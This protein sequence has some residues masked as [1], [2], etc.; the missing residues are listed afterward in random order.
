M[1]RIAAGVV[2]GWVAVAAVALLAGG[3]LDDVRVTSGTSMLA[4]GA[5]SA[6]VLD[7]LA[8]QDGR[9]VPALV[10]YERDGPLQAGDLKAARRD[11]RRFTAV[12][13]VLGTASDPVPSADG[14]A[15]QTTVLVSGK[16]GVLV[17]PV[18][19]ELRR[20]A[21]EGGPPGL[22][23]YV[24]GAVGAAADYVDSFGHV[25][26]TLLALSVGVVL[27]VLLAVYRSPVLWVIP[28][29]AVV[30]AY[31]C[32]AAAVYALARAGVMTLRA[33]TP[34]IF[35]VLVF[36]VATDYALLLVA[37]YRERLRVTADERAALKD[38]LSGGIRTVVA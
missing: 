17:S 37:R 9:V 26:G 3:P 32:S 28:M 19:E 21:A 16:P 24:S 20:I 31:I 12:P 27:L 29:L 34:E 2:L 5:E 8:K 1:R 11:L 6:R 7:L 22:V 23:T 13:N 33:A 18:A 10:I 14:R 4:R 25:D 38:A 15:L 36:G 35:T 30:V